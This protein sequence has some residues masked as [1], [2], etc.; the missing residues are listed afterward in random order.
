MILII[1][2]CKEKLSENEFVKPIANTVSENY[3]IK[4]YSE[5]SKKEIDEADKIIICGTALIDNEY[6]ENLDKFD[7]IKNC[8]K[9]V[10]GICSGMQIIGLIFGADIIKEKEIGMKKIEV[11]G[12]SRL[13]PK[14]FEAYELHSNSLKN[15]DSFEILA[16]SGE[17]IQAIK[18]KDEEI[19]GI[20]FH[21]EVRNAQIIR[22]FLV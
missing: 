15:L 7:W 5:I 4:H 12:K 16:K 1:S 8:D 20:I 22:K 6:L 2:T 21:P 9:P 18:H 3:M 11:I 13:F 10:L 17:I 14:T 19:F